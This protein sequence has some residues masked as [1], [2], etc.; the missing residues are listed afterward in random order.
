MSSAVRPH[1]PT[2][3]DDVSDHEADHRSDWLVLGGD[4]GGTS[5]RFLLADRHGVVH[6]RGRAG[7]GNPIAHPQTA[8]TEVVR[9]LR[10]ALRDV[11]PARVRAVVV[12]VAGGFA[13]SRPELGLMFDQAWAAVGVDC[14]ASYV[15]DLEVAFASGTTEPDGTV[16]IAGTGAAAARIAARHVVGTADG[17]GWLLGDDGSGFWLGREAAR[18]TL[19]TLDEGQEPGPLVAAVLAQLARSDPDV[20]RPDPMAQRVHLIHVVNE[21]APVKLAELAPLVGAAHRAGDPEA[22][23]IVAEAAQLLLQT[24]R[25]VR[26]TGESSPIVLAG[27]VAGEESPVGAALRTGVEQGFSGR[28]C[29]AADGVGG[30]AWLALGAVDDGVTH[31]AWARLTGH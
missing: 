8:A 10:H 17:H 16:L 11:D 19:R 14:M 28:V 9:A 24:L 12:G 15:T 1:P 30:A 13:R 3:E 21:R 22:V 29:S 2:K 23:R 20:C 4:V 18:A 7:G 5:S 27:S 26:E 31:D 25:R 6:S